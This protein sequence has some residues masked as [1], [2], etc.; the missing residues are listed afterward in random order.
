MPKLGQSTAGGR[1]GGRAA[2][3]PRRP[4]YD[5]VHDE[6]AEALRRQY[7]AGD[8][9]PSEPELAASFGV[10]RPTMREVLRGLEHEGAVR[11]AH[12]VGTFVTDAPRKVTSAAEV[13]LGVTEAV[14]AAASRLGVHVLSNGERLA[15]AEIAAH[16]EMEPDAPVVWIERLILADDSPAAHVVDVIPA[17]IA[18]VSSEPYRDGSVYRFLEQECGLELVGGAARITAQPATRTIARLLRVPIGSPLLQLEQVE[19]TS[20][21][22]ACLYSLELYVPSAFDLTVA[23]KRRGRHASRA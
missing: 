13:D 5:Q 1:L 23:R 14:I 9:L 4:L 2:R 8:R 18:G 19:R 21:G 10:S 16:L 20:Q 22:V 12:G 3:P 7:H 17:V 11:R 15:T 6:L